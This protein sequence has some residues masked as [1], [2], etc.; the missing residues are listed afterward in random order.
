MGTSIEMFFFW[1]FFGNSE[2]MFAFIWNILLSPK[3]PYNPGIPKTF[4][5]QV[6]RRLYTACL[7]RYREGRQNGLEGQAHVALIS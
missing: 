1:F 6:L 5:V 2:E 4:P 3:R 7:P